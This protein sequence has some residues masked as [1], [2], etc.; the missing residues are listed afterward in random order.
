MTDAIIFVILSQ[1]VCVLRAM[2]LSH[3][4]KNLLCFIQYTSECFKNISNL[5]LGSCETIYGCVLWNITTVR[6]KLFLLSIFIEVFICYHFYRTHFLY[7][8]AILEVLGKQHSEI[9]HCL[10]IYYQDEKK[11]VFLVKFRRSLCMNFEKTLYASQ[12]SLFS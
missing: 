1:K 12:K 2:A 10:N 3:T 7:L 9:R 11:Q 6:I 5:L 8:L 4:A